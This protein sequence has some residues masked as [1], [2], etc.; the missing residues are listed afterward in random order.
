[1][2]KWLTSGVD[3]ESYAALQNKIEP[4]VSPY[5][6][7][8]NSVLSRFCENSGSLYDMIAERSG[9]RILVDSSKMPG[10][11]MALT[12]CENIDLRVIHLVRD[13]RAVAHSMTRPYKLDLSK[14]I[15]KEIKGRSPYRTAMRW[16]LYNDFSE[17]LCRR[18]GKDRSVTVRYEDLLED[19]VGELGNIGEK[20]GIDLSDVAAKLLKREPISP[21][22]QMA[23]SRIRLQKDLVLSVDNRW[24]DEITA[25]T[26]GALSWI[27]KGQ[28]RKYGY[29]E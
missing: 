16:R 10:R 15:Q 7:V 23:G 9:A 11:G 28:L 22:H 20:I 14:G 21:G 25:D 4:L 27:A 13:G 8:S 1:M 2:S 5:R 12:Q 19:P 6:S 3:L 17:A 24:K 18:V 26:L 29:L